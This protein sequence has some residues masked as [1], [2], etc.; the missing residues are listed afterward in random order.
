MIVQCYT[1]L[2]Y[3]TETVLLIFSFLQ[4]NIT[5]NCTDE[6]KWR[7]GGVRVKTWGKFLTPESE[8]LPRSDVGDW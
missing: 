6:A 8:M 2:G 1:I 5:V 7:L 3:S 4:I